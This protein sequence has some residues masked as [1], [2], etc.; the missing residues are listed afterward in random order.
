MLHYSVGQYDFASMEKALADCGANGG[1][2]GDNVLVLDCSER[3]VDVSGLSRH[4]VSRNQ[5]TREMLLRLSIR[6]Y[7]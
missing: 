5:L 6:W 4:K 7:Y 1:I 3:F 2:C